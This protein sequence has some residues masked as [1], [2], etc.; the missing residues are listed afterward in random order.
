MRLNRLSLLV[1]VALVVTLVAAC[2]TNHSSDSTAPVFLSVNCTGCLSAVDMATQ[3]DDVRMTLTIN[4]SA[5]SPTGTLS[6]Q[7]DVILNLWVITPQRS[8]GGTIASPQARF[9]NTVYVPAGGSGTATGVPVFPANYF[10]QM[11]LSQLFPQNGGVDKET[12]NCNIR[13]TLHIQI[14]GKTVSGKSISVAFDDAVNFY[15]GTPSCSTP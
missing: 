11:P 1:P 14:F 13:Q 8:D 6:V 4:S 12:G 3:V 10:A 9:T 15:Y 7:D 5:K 2:G